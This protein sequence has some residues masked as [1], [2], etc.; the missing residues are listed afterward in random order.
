MHIAKKFF[1]IYTLLLTFIVGQ[2]Q[3]ITGY[4]IDGRTNQPIIG[5][6]ILV[7]GTESGSSSDEDG[8]FSIKWSGVFPIK[9]KITHI[10]YEALEQSINNSGTYSFRLNP[11][12]LEGQEVNITGSRGE[13]EKDISSAVEIVT[14]R[15]AEIRGI[16]DISEVL[17]EMES[18]KV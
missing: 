6:N 10:A 3:T 8:K 9:L 13:A 11:T 12:V 2:V 17:R 16:R 18:R 4:V 7:V 5:A 15:K 1:T 14:V